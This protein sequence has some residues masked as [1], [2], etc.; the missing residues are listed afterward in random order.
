M[1]KKRYCPE[2]ING[3]LHEADVLICQGKKV[4]DVIKGFGITDVTYSRWRQEFGG[5]SVSQARRLKEL[6]KEKERLRKAVSDLTLDKL[7]L[8]D[9]A[10]L[11]EK[12]RRHYNGVRPH[13]A[14]GYRPPAPETTALPGTGLSSCW[15]SLE[16]SGG[17][18]H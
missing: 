4:M 15:S 13:G 7:I 16:A 3:K 17:R 14:L 5:M 18:L 6:E 10:I 2:E 11:I 8:K 1:A 12:W 9:A